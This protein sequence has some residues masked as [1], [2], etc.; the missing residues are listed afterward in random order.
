[1]SSKYGIDRR[2][3]TREVCQ[4]NMYL[5]NCTFGDH[6]TVRHGEL[7]WGVDTSPPAYVE[8]MAT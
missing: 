4:I 1:M 5:F 2:L 3:G 6:H 7:R 8:S